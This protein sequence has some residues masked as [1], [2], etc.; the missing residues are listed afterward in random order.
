MGQEYRLKCIGFGS[1]NDLVPAVRRA[2]YV[3]WAS[4]MRVHKIGS[5]PN[6]KTGKVQDVLG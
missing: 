4:E 1:V 2:L 6:C 5:V 3:G